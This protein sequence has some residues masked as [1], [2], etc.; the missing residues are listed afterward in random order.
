MEINQIKNDIFL[1]LLKDIQFIEES[2]YDEK[3][4]S[5]INSILEGA[6]FLDKDLFSNIKEISIEMA[7]SKNNPNFFIDKMKQQIKSFMD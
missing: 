3:S 5:K 2:K 4:L 1:S 7:Y 6:K